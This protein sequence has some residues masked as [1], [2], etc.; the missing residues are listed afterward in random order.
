MGR[1]NIPDTQEFNEDPMGR[2]IKRNLHPHSPL[3][4]SA[5]KYGED[6]LLKKYEPSEEE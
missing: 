4:G 3:G 5:S 2:Y 6:E 1:R